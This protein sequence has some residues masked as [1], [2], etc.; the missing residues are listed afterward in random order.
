VSWLRERALWLATAEASTRPAAL[1]RIGLVLLLWV[2]YAKSFIL[3]T[4]LDP[5]YI[6]IG[7]SFWL[8]TTLLFF[9]VFSRLSATW[10]GVTTMAGIYF[11]LGYERGMEPF[12]HH[13]TYLLCISPLLLALTPC[14][15]SYSFDRWWALRSA[16]AAGE[17]PPPERGPLWGQYLIAFQIAMI[18]LWGAVDKTNAAYL[19]G[20]RFEHYLMALYF[21][22]D[23]PKWSG[24]APMCTFLAVSSVV[25][26]YALVP[27]LFLRRLQ[28]LLIPIAM[29]FHAII[30]YTMPVGTFTLNM[31]LFYIAFIHP[32][33]VHDFIDRMSGHSV[34]S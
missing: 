20:E 8:S 27:G 9:G 13:H 21:G 22:S 16:D 18:Y 5:A 6:G 17:P 28:P 26:E 10:A 11:F 23:Y 14:G 30:Y 31:W 7:A 4:K 34:S 1:M 25:L 3:F 29:I 32:D 24:F 2:R 15:G 12:T 33:V 19:S